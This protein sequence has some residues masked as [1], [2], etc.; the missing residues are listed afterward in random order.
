MMLIKK[1]QIGKLLVEQKRISQT[2]MDTALIRQSI[3]GRKLGQVLIELGLI[4]EEELMLL[5]SEQLKLPLISLKDFE[6][7]LT[8]HA[9][10]ESVARRFQC[11]ILKKESNHLLIGMVDPQD[12]LAL[13]ELVEIIKQPIEIA[14]VRESELEE[15]YKRIY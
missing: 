5:L 12:M 14:L 10:P 2:D 13:E 4:E 11:I 15:A 8:I 6:F 1:I 7:D 3:S 9:L